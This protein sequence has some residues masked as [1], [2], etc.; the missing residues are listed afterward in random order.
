[1]S[2]VRLGPTPPPS[3]A[4]PVGVLI[5]CH[6]R[7]EDKL[8]IL[9]RSVAAL[10]ERPDEALAAI[11]D[12]VRWLETAGA[13][14]TE[15]EEA[16]F[17]PCIYGRA[18]LLADLQAEHRAAEAILLSLRAVVRRVAAEPAVLPRI[19]GELSTHAA[20]LAATYRAHLADEETRF[21]PLARALDEAELRAIGL[22]MRIRRGGDGKE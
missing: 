6:R 11:A 20:A 16:S 15:D 18:D 10:A 12:A 13:R 2:L 17:F 1:V 8:A 21:L 14:H 22:E 4:D 5:A 7:I 9:E 3:F 19:A